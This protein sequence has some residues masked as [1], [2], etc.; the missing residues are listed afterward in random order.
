M[1]VKDRTMPWEE[2]G[3]EPGKTA[4]SLEAGNGFSP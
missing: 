4:Q 3:H 2:L 1:E